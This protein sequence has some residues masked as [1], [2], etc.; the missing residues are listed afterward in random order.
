MLTLLAA[1]MLLQKITYG[2]ALVRCYIRV[3]DPDIEEC[4][5]SLGLGP[6]STSSDISV[7]FVDAAKSTSPVIGASTGS[8]TTYEQTSVRKSA[9][10]IYL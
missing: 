4:I 5:L 10:I 8:T 1:L 6:E 2:L 7:V 3:E 9:T